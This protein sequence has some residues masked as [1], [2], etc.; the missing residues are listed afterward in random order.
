MAYKLMVILTKVM[1]PLP[2]PDKFKAFK[3]NVIEVNGHDID[4][5]HQCH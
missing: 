4:E 3:W 1:S 2:I 5:L